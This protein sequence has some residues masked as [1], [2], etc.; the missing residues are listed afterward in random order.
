MQLH[1]AA[2]LLSRYLSPSR[3]KCQCAARR[4]WGAILHGRGCC[5]GYA[6]PRGA[7]P[8][9]RPPFLSQLTTVGRLL[10]L[11]NACGALSMFAVAISETRPF[12]RALRWFNCDT[13]PH[14][15]T[16]YTARLDSGTY[17]I[18]PA[19][20]RMAR[21]CSQFHCT[22]RPEW[23]T[24]GRC[25][26]CNSGV[27][28]LLPLQGRDGLTTCYS[29]LPPP[30]SWLATVGSLIALLITCGALNIIFATAAGG[31]PLYY[32]FGPQVADSLSVAH[33]SS[34]LHRDANLDRRALGHR[35]SHC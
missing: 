16:V 12:Y 28:F 17:T 34:Q 27:S 33:C 13:A 15:T 10:A 4:P 19:A 22:A 18:A 20:A 26:C 31:L 6:A 29:R 30:T 2:S 35:R 7:P 25:Y 21:R 8:L 11:L 3:G 1:Q 9:Q 5:R 23:F 24:I 14:M 32:G